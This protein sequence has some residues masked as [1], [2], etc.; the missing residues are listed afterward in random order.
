MCSICRTLLSHLPRGFLQCSTTSHEPPPY[1]QL[2]DGRNN[3]ITLETH[4]YVPRMTVFLAVDLRRLA[5]FP[6]SVMIPSLQGFADSSIRSRLQSEAMTG[7]TRQYLN[8]AL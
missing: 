5:S 8:Q 1:T 3:S 6:L 7:F 2:S 4:E